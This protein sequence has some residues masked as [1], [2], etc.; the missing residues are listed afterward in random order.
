MALCQNKFS[1]K[2]FEYGFDL[3][4]NEPVRRNTLSYEWFRTKN[5]FVTEVK[6]TWKWPIQTV[7]I[8]NSVLHNFPLVI[9]YS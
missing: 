1:C 4:E 9:I 6:L 7:E 8:S 2:T 5:C 3:H